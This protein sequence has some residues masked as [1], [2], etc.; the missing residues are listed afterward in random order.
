[1]LRKITSYKFYENENKSDLEELADFY[2]AH[3]DSYNI[4]NPVTLY[5]GRNGHLF[6]ITAYSRGIKLKDTSIYFG[7]R[8]YY[9]IAEYSLVG[10]RNTENELKSSWIYFEVIITFSHQFPLNAIETFMWSLSIEDEELY[11]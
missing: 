5:L 2:T 7:N 8:W 9:D 3:I 10:E 6:R 11:V 1:M 4:N